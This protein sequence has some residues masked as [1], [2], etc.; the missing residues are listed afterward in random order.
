M[1]LNYVQ[2]FLLTFIAAIAMGLTVSNLF[3]M[4]LGEALLVSTPACLMVG[5]LF[6]LLHLAKAGPAVAAKEQIMMLLV[7]E[8]CLVP[9]GAAA[10]LVGFFV[11]RA[12][13]A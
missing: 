3:G 2:R 1:Q 5:S 6:V 4:R 8:F 9:L 10:A 7:V 11:L 12:P 13:G